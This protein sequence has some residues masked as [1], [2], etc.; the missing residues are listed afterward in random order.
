MAE[1][2]PERLLK[3]LAIAG[4]QAIVNVLPVIPEKEN[5]LLYLNAAIEF[6]QVGVR[7]VEDFDEQS[8]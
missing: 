2:I 5:K 6:L 7:A 4:A 8:I 1:P 3:Q